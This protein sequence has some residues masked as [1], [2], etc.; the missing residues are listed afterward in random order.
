MENIWDITMMR[1]GIRC[2]SREGLE[3]DNDISVIFIGSMKN[4]G[5]LGI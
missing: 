1:L 3:I 5:R 2:L 4:K